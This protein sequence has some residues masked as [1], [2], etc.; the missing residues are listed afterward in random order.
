MVGVVTVV[1]GI[2]YV[3]LKVGEMKTRDAQ[4]KSDVSLVARALGEY[5]VDHKSLPAADDQGRIVLCGGLQDLAC[6]WGNARIVDAEGVSYLNNL[7]A[8]PFKDQGRRY[9]YE[10]RKNNK[11]RLYVSVE[12][13]ADPDYKNNLTI[14]CGENVQCNWY[15]EW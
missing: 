12:N 13:K 7:P 5:L 1:V 11:Y 4:R 6:E 15:V 2:S 14:K 9:V 3:Q 10:P 8:D